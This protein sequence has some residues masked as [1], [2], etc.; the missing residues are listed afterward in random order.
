GTHVA[1]RLALLPEAEAEPVALLADHSPTLDIT[2][3]GTVVPFRQINMAAEVDGRVVYKAPEARAGNFVKKGQLLYRIDPR[4]FE[5]TVER[6]Q[7]ML[8]QEQALLRELDQDVANTN[9]MLAV[10][11]EELA[12]H[13]ADLNR[14]Q[15]LREGVAS[16][17]EVDQVKRLRLTSVN[18]M[19]TLENQLQSFE[20]RRTRLE[21][22]KRLASNQLDQAKLNLSRCE[23][24][25]PVDGIIASE[26]AQADSYT[27]KGDALATLED[28]GSVEVQCNLRVDQLMWVLDQ[29]AARSTG[30]LPSTEPGNAY[31]LPKTP[32]T[33]EFKVTGREDLVYR[34]QGHLDR[35]DG[36]GID[37]QSRTVPCR[38][39]VDSPTAFTV[40]GQP[41]STSRN[42]GLSA[43]VR[44][45]FVDVIIAAKPHSV[46]LLVPR[47]GVKPGNIIW[48]FEPTMD[49]L[50]KVSGSAQPGEAPSSDGSAAKSE[51]VAA[52]AQTAGAKSAIKAAPL[53]PEEWDVGFLKLLT[54][55]NVVHTFEVPAPAGS[56][57]SE[58]AL[59]YWICEVPSGSLQA[60]DRVIVSPLSG[61]AGDGSDGLRVRKRLP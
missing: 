2:V 4:D 11:K 48:K 23:I 45:M 46:L 1:S 7:R 35:Y 30:Q 43:L 40:N 9:R 59:K 52:D 28:L 44:G 38:V 49:A 12:L 50:P 20:T 31:A 22:A 37:P 15:S 27:R 24:T 58:E 17:A 29:Q 47:L 54:K 19:T 42:S 34:W 51:N 56:G 36:S 3:S 16:R 61:I 14:L 57:A 13:D 33:I 5:L 39:V 41:P 18:Q 32:V 10:N 55:I 53:N 26:M 21:L 6:L 60:G 8:E 25:A